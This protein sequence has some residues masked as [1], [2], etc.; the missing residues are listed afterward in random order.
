MGLLI[1]LV[2]YALI[3]VSKGTMFWFGLLLKVAVNNFS[4]ML[5]PSHRFL[6]ITSTLG[7][8]VNRSC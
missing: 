1:C 8:G 2:S 6:S 4:V 7:G 3:L 5:G